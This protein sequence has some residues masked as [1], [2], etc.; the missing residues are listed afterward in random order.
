MTADDKYSV[1]NRDYLRQPIPM[2]LSKQKKFFFL[3]FNA[4]FLKFTWKF[5]KFFKEDE[6]HRW[7]ICEIRDWEKRGNLYLYQARIRTPL[8]SQHI[9]GSQT[10]LKSARQHFNHIVLS[11]WENLCW[12]KFL[13]VIS[14]IQNYLLTYWLPTTCILFITKRIYSNHRKCNYLKSSKFL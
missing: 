9:K 4:A 12:K 7:C 11:L 3:G 13:L 1:H 6:P 2:Q 14:E 5:Q 10:L 8:D